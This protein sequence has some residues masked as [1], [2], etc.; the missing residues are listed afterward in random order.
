MENYRFK[1]L[2]ERAFEIENEL[3]EQGLMGPDFEIIGAVLFNK[4]KGEDKRFKEM[5]E[6][7]AELIKKAE[8]LLARFNK[9][10]E[11]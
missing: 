5:F 10:E 9:E 11:L 1:A 8:E 4:Y 6:N 7:T 2:K 3:K